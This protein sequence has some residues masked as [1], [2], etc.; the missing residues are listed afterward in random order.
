MLLHH[1][2]LPFPFYLLHTNDQEQDAGKEEK[3]R[4]SRHRQPW[5]CHKVLIIKTAAHSVVF[6]WAACNCTVPCCVAKHRHPTSW[7][8]SRRRMRSF[9]VMLGKCSDATIDVFVW[10]GGNLNCSVELSL[11]VSMNQH[12][13][14]SSYLWWIWR[15][16]ADCI[17][18][19]QTALSRAG[20]TERKGRGNMITVNILQ[21]LICKDG[22]LGTSRVIL[23]YE[24]LW[25]HREWPT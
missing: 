20:I 23:L 4:T 14:S 17:N 24:W 19:P 21:I 8:I 13:A 15:H 11:E 1:F 10:N 6:R 3:L 9:L 16:R 7:N 22:H 12:K 5:L 25:E 2:A 18:F